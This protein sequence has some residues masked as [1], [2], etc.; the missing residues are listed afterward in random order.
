[1]VRLSFALRFSLLDQAMTIFA[2]S[3]GSLDM[4]TDEMNPET[5]LM[6]NVP[7]NTCNKMKN[8]KSHIV[9]TVSKFKRQNRNL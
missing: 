7:T 4:E 3:F 6:C 1:L 2:I 9:E 5:S 8:N